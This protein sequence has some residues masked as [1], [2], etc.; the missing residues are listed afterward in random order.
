MYS[1]HSDVL[2]GLNFCVPTVAVLSD[3]I[4]AGFVAAPCLVGVV[5]FVLLLVD[6]ILA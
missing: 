1:L 5:L 2:Y 3:F 6:A 4:S